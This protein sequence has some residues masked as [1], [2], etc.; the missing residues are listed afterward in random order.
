MDTLAIIPAYNEADKIGE[1][2]SGIRGLD[3]V[4]DIVVIDDGS[5]DGTA[6][7]A[8]RAGATVLRLSSNM[9]YGVAVQTA[10]KYAYERGYAYGVQL[11]AD[12]QHDPAYLP[13]ILDGVMSDEADLIIGSRF[14]KTQDHQTPPAN[15]YRA[16]M[17]RRSGIILFAALASKLIGIKITDPTSG[18][19]A[20]NR[21][22]LA[23]FVQ[24]FFPYEYPDAD[25]IVMV[26]RAGF[27]IKEMPMV[28][29]Q[30]NT[31]ASMYTGLKPL[32]YVFKMFFSILMTLMRK[33]PSFGMPQE[34]KDRH[35]EKIAQ[36]I[37]K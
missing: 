36:E 19:R 23:F 8:R 31:G 30:R 37:E 2:L 21:K 7:V 1:V 11:D 34:S 10:Y 27:R 4:L 5:T 29:Y 18:Y 16:G 26:H 35:P 13:R 12:G 22:L 9:G 17:I 15:G 24:D 28:M 6:E 3:A 32:Y 33:R 25:V 20:W 14:L